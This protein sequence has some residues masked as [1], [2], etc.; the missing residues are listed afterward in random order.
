[1]NIRI[2]NSES[3]NLLQRNDTHTGGIGVDLNYF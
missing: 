3:E 2:K 1:M